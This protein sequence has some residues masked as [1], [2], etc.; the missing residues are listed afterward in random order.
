M[1]LALL[2]D[3]HGNAF[4]LEAVLNDLYRRRIDHIICLGDVL[5]FGPQPLECLNRVRE[6][7]CPV[8]MGNADE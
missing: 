8:V 4:A 7:N 1:R 5:P 2:S 6:L 3:I